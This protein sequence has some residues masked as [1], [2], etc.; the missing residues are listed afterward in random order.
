MKL[1]VGRLGTFLLAVWLILM[2]LDPLLNLEQYFP[3]KIVIAI[4][5]IV[6]GILIILD[7]R[8]KATKNLGRLLLSIF[9][10]LTGLFPLLSITFPTQQIIMAVFAIVAGVLLLLG[11]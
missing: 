2:G 1:L 6:A 9:L 3:S 7:I 11:R 10:I 8:E 5:A 4:I